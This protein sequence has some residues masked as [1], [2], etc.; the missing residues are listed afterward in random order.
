[1]IRNRTPRT[2]ASRYRGPRCRAQW[3]E[4]VTARGR[5][6]T[7]AGSLST[8]AAIGAFGEAG[9]RFL[10]GPRCR[11]SPVAPLRLAFVECGR[12]L[13]LLDLAHGHKPA[14]WNHRSDEHTR[15]AKMTAGRRTPEVTPPGSVPHTETPQP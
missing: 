14:L 3:G 10:S 8:A 2:S 6:L 13:R 7:L 9:R 1:M 4:A 5:A 12:P 15:A 11:P